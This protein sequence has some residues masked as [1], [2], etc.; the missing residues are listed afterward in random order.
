MHWHHN[1]DLTTHRVTVV[2]D[3]EAENDQAYVAQEG[4]SIENA[5]TQLSWM[6]KETV[7]GLI[8]RQIV[9]LCSQI[10]LKC[11]EKNN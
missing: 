10:Q 11:D 6:H 7:M 9:T 4:I 8:L 2:K 5:Y 1:R 3:I